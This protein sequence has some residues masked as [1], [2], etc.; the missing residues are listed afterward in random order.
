MFR[1]SFILGPRTRRHC[2]YSW[3]SSGWSLGGLWVAS[4]LAGTLLLSGHYPGTIRAIGW[5][6][7]DPT[8][9]LG[10]RAESEKLSTSP[11]TSNKFNNVNA[12]L[13]HPQID[14][15]SMKTNG[16]WDRLWKELH[17]HQK[18]HKIDVFILQV[19]PILLDKLNNLDAFTL[20]PK[21]DNSSMKTNGKWDRIWTYY[22]I[23]LSLL[24]IKPIDF[25]KFERF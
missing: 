6:F 3:V 10:K 9:C 4:G 13:L 24:H 5:M 16:K 11:S 15:S 22:I 25:I 17:L 21:I 19:F 20:H 14:N 7:V 18:Y 23:C 1:L 8:R 12:F 2:L